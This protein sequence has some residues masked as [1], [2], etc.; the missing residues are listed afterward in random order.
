MA[1]Y[2]QKMRAAAEATGLSYD[3]ARNILYGMY[4]GFAF[5]TPAQPGNVKYCM[6]LCCVTHDGA[7][8]SDAEGKQ[9]DKESNKLVR[10][11]NSTGGIGRFM[12]KLG[13]DE[14]STAQV[15]TDALTYLTDAFAERGYANTC[16]GCHQPVETAACAVG[17][18]LRFLCPNCFEDVA[19]N[20]NEK[21]HLDEE[22]PENMAAGLVGALGGALLGGIVV[23]ILGQL[24]YVASLSGLIAAVCALKGYELL[25][26]KMSVKGAIIA[27]VAVLI[28][29][30][31]GHRA[32]WAIEI[33]KVFKSE[34]GIDLDFFTAFRSVPEVVRTVEASDEYS[35]NLLMVYLFAALGAVPTVIKSLKGQKTKYTVQKLN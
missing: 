20:L 26:K 16:E 9:I 19:S 21:A 6:M 22:T 32:D 13:K 7:P 25:A 30:Y 5:A 33:M 4:R 12:V 24:G 15:L 1:T 18:G 8:L 29:I 3:Q 2:T 17:N 11:T 27:C 14:R 28:M 10:F 35:K 34:V 23:L 31:V